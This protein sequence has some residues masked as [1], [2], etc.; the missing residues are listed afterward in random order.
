MQGCNAFHVLD[1][2]LQMQCQN[3]EKNHDNISRAWSLY[4][5]KKYSVKQNY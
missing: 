1:L 4:H 3:E 2:K 5:G